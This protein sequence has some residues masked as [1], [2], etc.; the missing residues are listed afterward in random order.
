MPNIVQEVDRLGQ[1]SVMV[2]G[3]I[4]IDGCMDLVVVSVNLIPAG[5]IEQILQ[6]HVLV[7]AYCVGPEFILMHNNARAHVPHIIR[8]ALRELDI[9]E[10]EW[11]AVS[12]NL[13]PTRLSKTSNRLL[14]KNGT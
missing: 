4:S 1:G 11:P 3:G 5:Y 8:A 7:A 2:W 13:N 10:M 9:Q 12:P 14:L 6:Q